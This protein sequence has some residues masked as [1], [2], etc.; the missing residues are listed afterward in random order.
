M[1]GFVHLRLVVMNADG[2]G[3]TVL[4]LNLTGLGL[5]TADARD[6]KP[7]APRTGWLSPPDQFT[8]VAA[9]DP[10]Q[11]NVPNALPEY[12][13]SQRGLGDI[14]TS[15]IHNPNVYANP[16]LLTPFTNNSPPPGSVAWAELWLD[17]NQFTGA[18]CYPPAYPQP[19]DDFRQDNE[20]R[21]VLWDTVPVTPAGAFTMT[22]PADVMGF[23]VLRDE[24]GRLVR[25]WNRGYA[26][27]AQ[28]SSWSR[29]GEAVTCTGCHMGHVSGSLDD[30][31]ELAQ[32][33]W[34]NVAPYAVASASSYHQTAYETFV[35]GQINDRRGWI[36]APA[37]G[38]D[39]APR[40]TEPYQ[41]GYQDA[42]TGWKS[43][44]G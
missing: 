17:T 35:P 44:N 10:A 31:L 7:I 20:L 4:P 6:A 29:P 19:C 16:S 26:S 39:R 14:A 24:N 41:T 8:D 34:Q 30:V 37:H 18:F 13:F 11:W 28:G 36:P 12:A 27:I 42:T 9:D 23:I 38:P 43:E 25:D 33:G 21:A 2:R 32:E 1:G 3:K 40:L 22:V 15:V 5:G